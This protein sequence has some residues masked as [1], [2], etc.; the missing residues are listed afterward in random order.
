MARCARPHRLAICETSWIELR[1]ERAAAR[2]RALSAATVTL[3]DRPAMG[4]AVEV[5]VTAP[6]AF[7]DCG[8]GTVA[9]AGGAASVAV[10]PVGAI[11]PAAGGDP[12]PP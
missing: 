10:V 9:G 11:A 12:A 6:C 7:G 2:Y 4:E 5:V 1:K 3:P 8:A